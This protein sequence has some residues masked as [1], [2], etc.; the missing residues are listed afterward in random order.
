MSKR[1]RRRNA[2]VQNTVVQ[3]EVQV[4][5]APSKIENSAPGYELGAFGFEGFGFGQSAPFG[6]QISNVDSAY[7]NL[8]WYFV[9]NFRQVLSQLYVEIGLVQTIV[10]VPVDDAFRGGIEIKSKQLDEQQIEKL[11]ISVDR[12]DDLNTAAQAGKWNRLYGGAAIL[13]LVGDQ[14]PEEPL[15]VDAIGQD[16]DL[17]FRAVD[18]WELYGDKQDTDEYDPA[19]LNQNFE[20]YDYYG[21]RLHKSRV[22]RLKAL[23]APSFLRPRLRGWGMSVV[24]ALIRSMNQYLKATDLAFEVLDEFK[25]DVY[26]VKNLVTTLMSAN[27][28]QKVYERIRKT[29]WHQNAIVLDSEDDWDNKQLTFAGLAETMQGIRMQVAADMRMPITKL[30]GTSTS[31]GFKTDQNDMENY[32]SMVEAQVRNKLK[33]DILRMLELKC[34]KLFGFVPD[35]LAIYFKPLRVLSAEEE[36]NV[37]TQKFNRLIQAKERAELTTQEFRDAANKGDLFDIKL[38]TKAEMLDPNDPELQDVASDGNKLPS[39]ASD[40][41]EMKDLKKEA[42]PETDDQ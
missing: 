40:S 3:N 15:D 13:I 5:N 14:D 21:H 6:P 19:V 38:D 28:H 32:N 12:D 20:F 36:E 4:I 25:V 31:S 11:K 27:G 26:K 2:R 42:K 39:D 10:D 29:N 22:L 41:S 23:P 17:E 1:D 8:R 30:F 34:Q 16:T 9:S 18:L 37:K 24:E 7:G 33:Y 35:D